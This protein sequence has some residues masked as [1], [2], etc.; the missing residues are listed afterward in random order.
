MLQSLQVGSMVEVYHVGGKVDVRLKRSHTLRECEG[1]V[2]RALLKASGVKTP[3]FKR[4][5]G[6][7]AGSQL[8]K[9]VLDGDVLADDRVLILQL[10]D[11]T[12][13]LFEPDECPLKLLFSETAGTLNKTSR[14]KLWFVAASAKQTYAEIIASVPASPASPVAFSNSM[15]SSSSPVTAVYPS[16]QSSLMSSSP[17]VLSRDSTATVSPMR[18]SAAAPSPAPSPVQSTPQVAEVVQV[19]TLEVSLSSVLRLNDVY[20]DRQ[21]GAAAIE[22]ERHNWLSQVPV[23]YDF[24]TEVRALDAVNAS[25]ALALSR[26]QAIER[27][28]RRG[29]GP[30]VDRSSK[31]K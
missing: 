16:R 13:R 11:G 5:V 29:V 31:P 8:K 20:S 6:K 4:S 12:Q 10:E 25:T 30:P 26:T 1:K 17:A 23:L 9:E 15:G 2:R 3:K 18:G 21:F 24:A 19:A 22:L 14:K 27:L 7:K 28:L